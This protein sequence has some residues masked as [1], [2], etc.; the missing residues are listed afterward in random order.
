MNRAQFMASLRAELAALPVEER[1]TALKYYEEYFDDAG[2]ENEQSVIAEL[3]SPQQV[4]QKIKTE[5]AAN[6][7][8][9]AAG[10]S[11][12]AK[13]GMPVWL[14]VIIA[15]F[16]IPVGFPL[17]MGLLGALIGI[18]AGLF[19]IFIGILVSGIAV[20]IS[21]IT[22][23]VAA[24]GLLALEPLHG[25]LLGGVG[26]IL[27]GIGMLLTLLIIRLIPVFIGWIVKLCKIPFR[28]RGAVV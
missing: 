11:A 2:P 7:A 16:A 1:E 5:L 22:L 10:A 13:S 25:L 4:A 12:K 17:L 27:T 18:L 28:K 26:L 21:G 3:G 14:L 23:I 15:V 6:S 8:A 9:A 24:I 20:F 19:G